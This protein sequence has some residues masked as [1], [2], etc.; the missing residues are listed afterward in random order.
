[1]AVENIHIIEPHPLQALIQAGN[2]VFAGS[3]VSVGTRPHQVARLAGDNQL[4][5]IGG[6]VLVEN[7]PKIF[8]G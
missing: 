5:T 7:A 3:P 8:F 1:M 6:K 4:I 2:Q